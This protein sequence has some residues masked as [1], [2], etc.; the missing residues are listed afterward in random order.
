M[1]TLS[2]DVNFLLEKNMT[3]CSCIQSLVR[4]VAEV[5]RLA[6]SGFINGMAINFT[7]Q[8]DQSLDE[9]RN[10][11]YNSFKKSFESGKNTLYHL[12]N[13]II[14]MLELFKVDLGSVISGDFIGENSPNLNAFNVEN[15]K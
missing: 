7:S 4:T 12:D 1:N 6:A 11:S 15:K 5:S 13:S 3:I 8:E 14:K 10:S 2:N 9:V